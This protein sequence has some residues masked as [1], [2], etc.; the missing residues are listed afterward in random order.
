MTPDKDNRSVA[1]L[2]SDLVQQLSTL[3]QT[4][5][6][7]L[8]SELTH[9]AH[10]AGAGAMEV[11]AGAILLLA[12]LLVLLQALVVALANLG[13]GAGWSSLLVGVAVAIFGAMLVKRGTTNMSSSELAPTRT[14]DQL[15]KDASL[16]K[17]QI[18]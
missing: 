12:A 3:V 10:K 14:A 13:L 7:L 16:L 4:E 17:E 1:T 9:S 11:A 8:R 18:R 5:G 15:G 6:R 2:L